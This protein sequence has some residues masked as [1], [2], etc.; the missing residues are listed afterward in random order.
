MIIDVRPTPALR[1]HRARIVGVIAGVA[2]SAATLV[3]V[4]ELATASS[5][6]RRASTS[7]TRRAADAPSSELAAQALRPN[8]C[9]TY[10]LP[11]ALRAPIPI[12][13]KSGLRMLARWPSECIHPALTTARPVG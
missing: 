2:L 1:R 5:R 10:H 3:P 6:A 9:A 11:P 12:S 8:T 7:P 4:A 13:R